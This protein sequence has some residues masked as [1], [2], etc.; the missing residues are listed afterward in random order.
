M[1]CKKPTFTLSANW[2]FWFCNLWFA[3]NTCLHAW[4]YSSVEAKKWECSFLAPKNCGKSQLIIL[5]RILMFFLWSLNLSE[6]EEEE[7]SGR[8]SCLPPP[9]FS[10]SFL[11]ESPYLLLD[12]I[13]KMVLVKWRI[14]WFIF[15]FL[16]FLIHRC[17]RHLLRH[18][19][20]HHHSPSLAS[21][22]IQV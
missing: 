20:H 14:Q 22:A 7:M 10:W 2:K 3:L 17:E 16:G 18:H 6:K 15:S 8:N 13:S 19:H 4:G 1:S 11:G 21:V 5:I 9:S 12:G